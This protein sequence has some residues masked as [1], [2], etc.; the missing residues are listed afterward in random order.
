M[1]FHALYTCIRFCCF[2]AEGRAVRVG[3]L[4]LREPG[5]LRRR[6]GERPQAR[7]RLL[8]IGQPA[9]AGAM[10]PRSARKAMR[11]KRCLD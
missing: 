4:H 11:G 8:L 2:F 9:V 5:G 7:K 1:M 6:V 10:V 3:H